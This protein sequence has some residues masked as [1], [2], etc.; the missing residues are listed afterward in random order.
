MPCPLLFEGAVRAVRSHLGRI[1]NCSEVHDTPPLP[2]SETPSPAPLPEPPPS[3]NNPP[4]QGASGRQLVERV[5]GVQNRGITP[6]G[7][8]GGKDGKG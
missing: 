2:T 8:G 3:Q 1:P 7:G 4:P 6:P 5:V